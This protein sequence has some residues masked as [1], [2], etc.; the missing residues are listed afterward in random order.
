MKKF[1]SMLLILC[2]MCM[3]GLSGCNNT[4]TIAGHTYDTYGVMNQDENKNPNIKYEVSIGSVIVG[5]IF[6]ESII[7]PLYIIGW[8]LFQPVCEKTGVTGEIKP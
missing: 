1:T 7:I 4:K 2:F 5:V 3:V 6:S 8:D